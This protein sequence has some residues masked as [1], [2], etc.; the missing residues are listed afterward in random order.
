MGSQLTA[1]QYLAY[2]RKHQT[3]TH[4]THAKHVRRLSACA[5]KVVGDTFVDV[6]C[7]LGHSTNI[8]RG[9]HTGEWTGIDFEEAAIIEARKLFRDV[10]FVFA[11]SMTHLGTLG[12][13]DSVVCSE[14]I[15]HVPDDVALV[16]NLL[17]IAKKRVIITTPSV[18]VNDVGH[19]RL[20]TLPTLMAL[21][22]PLVGKDSVLRVEESYNFLYATVDI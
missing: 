13:W 1:E 12:Q 6:G 7:A 17:K 2:W 16:T 8:M 10:K 9:Y 22:Q 11:E 15:E 4:L 19:V 20:Y 21:I 3:W 18:Y 5:G 14:V